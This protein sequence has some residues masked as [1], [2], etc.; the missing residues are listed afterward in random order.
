MLPD[1]KTRIGVF[2]ENILDRRYVTGTNDNARFDG[3]NEVFYSRPRTFGFTV[4]RLFGG[5]R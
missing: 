2:M 1:G 5:G 3:S 4:S